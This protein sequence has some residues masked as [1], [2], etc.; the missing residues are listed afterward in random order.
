MGRDREKNKDKSKDDSNTNQ[1]SSRGF[2]TADRFST[3]RRADRGRNNRSLQDK[4]VS[5]FRDSSYPSYPNTT[6]MH[7]REEV[8]T[9]LRNGHLRE[10]LSDRTKINDD[11]NSDN[12]EPAKIGED[13]PC[14]TINM[15]FGGKE[16]NGVTFSVAKK[17][18]VSVTHSKRLREV[19]EDDI[20][21]TEEDA[22]GLLL[23]YNDAL[24]ISLNVF[25]F[26]IKNVLVDPGSSANIIKWRALEQAKLTE[27]I[28]PATKLLAEFNL[29]SV[30]TR[31]KIMLPMNAEGVMKTTHF[32]VVDGDMVY[33]IIQGI[34]WLHE[35]KVVLST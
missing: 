18:K 17:T 16:I 12:A 7:F 15:I 35:M 20:N 19:A 1:H 33:N 13:P 23:P 8:A 25:D 14:L 26:K 5:G 27:S 6:S 24:V 10:L 30:R 11:C 29:E 9:L 31:G 4:E 32:E 28:I 3:N 34:S 21:F 22:D 2:R